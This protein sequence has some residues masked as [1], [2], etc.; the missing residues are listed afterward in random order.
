MIHKRSSSQFIRAVGDIV[1]RFS[2]DPPCFRLDGYFFCFCFCFLNRYIQHTCLNH[3][4]HTTSKMQIPSSAII[5]HKML[6]PF[7]FVCLVVF[8]FWKPDKRTL[9]LAANNASCVSGDCALTQTLG[10]TTPETC[11]YKSL[12]N[13]TG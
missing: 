8:F 6:P 13:E 10:N 5:A 11:D 12:P 4:A 7:P 2:F 1:T 9:T 3:R